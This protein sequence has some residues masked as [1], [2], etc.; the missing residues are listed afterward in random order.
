MNLATPNRPKSGR[1]VAAWILALPMTVCAVD[2]VTL[3]D[4]NKALAG[5]VTP[6]D[7]PGFPVTLSQPGSYRLAGTLTVPDAATTAIAITSSFVTLDLNGFSIIGPGNCDSGRDCPRGEGSGVIARLGFNPLVN[8]AIRN[9]SIKGMGSHGID[10][11]GNAVAVEQIVARGNGGAGIQIGRA[12]FGADS[13]A[14]SVRNS[15]AL[16]NGLSGIQL[17]EG[18]ISFNVVADNGN[19]GIFLN[20]GSVSNNVVTANRNKGLDLGGTAGYHGNALIG[21]G[22]GAQGGVNQGQNLCDSAACP[23]AVF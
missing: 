6:G 23:G 7:A 14:N 1:V 11:D 9:G 8:I 4:Q 22:V 3:I 21:N 10:V 18:L 20:R 13:R 5:N 16:N 2:G 15:A 19:S 12:R 17:D